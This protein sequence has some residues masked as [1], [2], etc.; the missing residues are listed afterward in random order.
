[1]RAALIALPLAAM[2]L[3]SG[4]AAIAIPA[5]AGAAIGGKQVLHKSSGGGDGRDTADAAA[6]V[7]AAPLAT[8]TPAPAPGAGAAV[9][10]APPPVGVRSI[11]NGDRFLFGSGE[12][13]ALSNQAYN[14]LATFLR[15]RADDRIAGYP[16]PAMV[17]TPAATLARPAF[18]DCGQKPLAVVLDIDETSVL[19]L[20]Y[21]ADAAQRGLGYD[22]DRWDRWE[23]TGG[24]AVA[25]LPGAVS[26][27]K[28]ARALGIVVVFNSNRTTTHADQT[29]AMLA[30][31]GLGPAVLGK[32]LFLR[33]P[34]TPGAKDARRAQIARRY[35]VVAMVGD[36]LGDFSDLFNAP[37]I[38]PA[39]RRAA[40]DGDQ[41]ASLWG[42][43]WFI[44]PNPVYG[45]ALAGGLDDVFPADKRWVDPGPA[46]PAPVPTPAP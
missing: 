44:L 22:A 4:C 11:P 43:G 1:M 39:Q 8:P 14:Q 3:N 45:T 32:T 25:A 37:G 34:G 31:A 26:A 24:K 20:G 35:C 6:L 28:K 41:F 12:A 29:A 46:A 30:G 15:A 23:A 40:A 33:D 5:M 9:A 13:A 16:V 2:A 42:A 17:L 10:A 36:Q 38:T 7:Q 18:D 19:N 27:L 21:E